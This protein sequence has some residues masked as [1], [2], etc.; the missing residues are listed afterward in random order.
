MISTACN[1]GFPKTK[2]TFGERVPGDPC[3]AS[4][5]AKARRLASSPESSPSQR[6]MRH[7]SW[8]LPARC[9]PPANVSAAIIR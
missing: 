4:D 5:T 9:P 2:Q 8:S 3:V 7:Q 6:R 1:S